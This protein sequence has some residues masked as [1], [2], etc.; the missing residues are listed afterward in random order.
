MRNSFFQSLSSQAEK[1]AEKVG[2]SSSQSFCVGPTSIEAESDPSRV[3]AADDI[4]FAELRLEMHHFPPAGQLEA[5]NTFLAPYIENQSWAKPSPKG[6]NHT[7]GSE[8]FTQVC[9]QF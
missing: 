2:I 3:V 9:S 8:K 7:E 5:F 4:S 6:R 1:V